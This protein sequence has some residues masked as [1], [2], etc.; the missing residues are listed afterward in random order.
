MQSE[1]HSVRYVQCEAAQQQDILHEKTSVVSALKLKVKKVKHVAP[2][3][4]GFV[5]LHDPEHDL[6]DMMYIAMKPKTFPPNY[7][8]GIHILWLPRDRQ[9]TWNHI[10]KL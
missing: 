9:N 4:A 7:R 2:Q 10:E 3:D 8:T 1:Q 5:Q 6:Q